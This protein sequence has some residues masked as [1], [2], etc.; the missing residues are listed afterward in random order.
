VS[1]TPIVE[2]AVLVALVFI[3]IGAA[4]VRLAG[5]VW[6]VGGGV[7][8]RPT[9][10]PGWGAA[11]RAVWLPAAAE[12]FGLTLLAALWFGSLGH[13]GWVTV[14]LLVGALAAGPERWLRHRLLQTP[15]RQEVVLFVLGLA[16]Y[17]AAGWLCAWRLS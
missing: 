9:S 4:S 8:S 11:L 16:R 5:G 15:V 13:G 6:G 14:F 12:A 2:A 1:G 7:S 3:V 17:A 10:P